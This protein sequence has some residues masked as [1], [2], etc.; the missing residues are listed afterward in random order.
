MALHDR[1][2]RWAQR[3]HKRFRRYGETHSR[4]RRIAKRNP[5]L[6]LH[7]ETRF[8]P[9]PDSRIGRGHFSINR[10]Y[11]KLQVGSIKSSEN[12]ANK[13]DTLLDRF[14]C[15]QTQGRHRGDERM[16]QKQIITPTIKVIMS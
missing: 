7:L 10:G 11:L 3:K 5:A 9:L 14:S 8:L 13:R 12:D 16:S 1:L 2:V 6:F 4:L 15:Y